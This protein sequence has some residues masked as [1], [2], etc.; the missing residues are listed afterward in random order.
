MQKS[1][2]Q[3]LRHIQMFE[4]MIYCLPD[5]PRYQEQYYTYFQELLRLEDPSYIPLQEITSL[6]RATKPYVY[7]ELIS[8]WKKDPTLTF[9]LKSFIPQEEA[10]ERLKQIKADI[11]TTMTG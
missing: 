2:E 10:E 3:V 8:D 4:M 5:N 7:E 6:L 11:L 9:L 1:E